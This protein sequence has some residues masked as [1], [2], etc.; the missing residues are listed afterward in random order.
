MASLY[1]PAEK[2]D[3]IDSLCGPEKPFKFLYEAAVFAA[4]VAV[5]KGV[6]EPLDP[7]SR[8]QEIPDRIFS[9]NGYGGLI[10]LTALQYEKSS[11][12]FTDERD[13]EIWRIFEGYCSAGFTEI[14]SWVQ[15]NPTEVAHDKTL[16]AK[17]SE[18]AKSN[19]MLSTATRDRSGI[20]F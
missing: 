2:N 17:I 6:W 19:R 1:M 18:K 5:D 7:K 3:L 20:D 16:I 13:A 10:Y 8:G 9:N 4:M 12:I 11:D 15:D 14:E